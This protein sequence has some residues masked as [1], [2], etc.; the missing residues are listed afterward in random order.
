MFETQTGL[1]SG[2][3]TLQMAMGQKWVKG[4]N[5]T[6]EFYESRS[7]KKVWTNYKQSRRPGWH[8]IYALNSFIVLNLCTCFSFIAYNLAFVFKMLVV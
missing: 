2:G 5:I 1:N 7:E 4:P 6:N 3:T 8:I